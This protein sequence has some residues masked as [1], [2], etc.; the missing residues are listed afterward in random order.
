M[1]IGHIANL[2]EELYKLP[3]AVKK[4][5]SFIQEKDCANLQPGKYE[6]DGEQIFV[7]VQKYLSKEKMECRAETHAKYIDIQ[8]VA[9]GEEY[10]GYC[11]FSS[12][13]EVEEDCLAERDAKFYKGFF[14]ESDVILSEGMYAVLYPNDVH[15]PCC[16]VGKPAEVVKLVFKISVE[17]LK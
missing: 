3:E 14:P 13:L 10:M 16:M 11:A 1:I 8:Y 17:A 12:Q 9:K 15:R 2:E 5:L 7:L 6:I 4:A